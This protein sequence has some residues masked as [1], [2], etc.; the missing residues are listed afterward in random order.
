MC[1]VRGIK[2]KYKFIKQLNDKVTAIKSNHIPNENINIES[3]VEQA[4]YD[5]KEQ[6]VTITLMTSPTKKP[7]KSKCKYCGKQIFP[8]Y[9]LRRTH[10]KLPHH[11][12]KIP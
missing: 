1:L 4:V 9:T 2:V 7:T 11:N 3:R 10:T 8:L 12:D 5:A 6:Y